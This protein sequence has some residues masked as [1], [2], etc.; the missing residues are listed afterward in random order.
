MIN[1]IFLM[2]PN[3]NSEETSELNGIE[4]QLLEIRAFIES[5]LNVGI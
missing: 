5:S 2:V 4:E 3:S 1:E